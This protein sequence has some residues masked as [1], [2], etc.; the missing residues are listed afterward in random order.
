MEIVEILRFK[1]PKAIDWKE[2]EK[3]IVK[4]IKLEH[5]DKSPSENAMFF[6][7]VSTRAKKFIRRYGI[8]RCYQMWVEANQKKMDQRKE[9]E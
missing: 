5:P 2:T 7:A 6:G 4:Q 1:S 3:A 8:E 9:K